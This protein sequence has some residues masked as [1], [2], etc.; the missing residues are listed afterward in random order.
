MKRPSKKD[1][2][3]ALAKLKTP[4]ASSEAKPFLEASSGS[5]NTAKKANKNRIRKQGV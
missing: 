3:E 1:I 2:Q 5:E 4:T